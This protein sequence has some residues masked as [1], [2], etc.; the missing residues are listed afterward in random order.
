MSRKKY[1]KNT[2]AAIL[3][4][5]VA[6]GG[7]ALAQEN[8]PNRPIQM[9]VPFAPGGDTDFNARVYSQYLTDE[10]G[11]S[12]PVLN[13][14]GAGGSIGA[15]QV[16]DAKPDGYTVLF[17]HSALFV[18]QASG[19]VDFSF[20]DFDFGAIVAR[21]A[22]NLIVVNSQSKW[23]SLE[24]LVKDSQA[25]PDTINITGNIGAT[26]YLVARLLNKAGARFSIID[27]GGSSERMRA[28]IGNHVE[29][30]QNPLGQIKPFVERGDV[31]ALATITD[32]RLPQFPDVPTTAEL[33]YDATFQYDYFFLFPKGTPPAVLKRFVDA[34]ERV[35]KNPKYIKDIGEKY[36][37]QPYF[38]RG[39]AALRRMEQ[40]EGIVQ[41]VDLKIA[42]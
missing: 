21:E 18:N 24:D 5:T 32:E 38:L 17:F 31:R 42:K 23:K 35:S 19:L 39:E 26:T 25:K 40:M 30:S 4:G 3:L 6:W 20:R 11:V 2:V 15:R 37:Q 41:S 22:G 16:K 10:L 8:W 36:Y 27:M 28:V 12:L 7:G 1:W 33:G 29:V 13:A 34:A 14:T 9:V